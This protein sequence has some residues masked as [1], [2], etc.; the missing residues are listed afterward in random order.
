MKQKTKHYPSISVQTWH[1]GDL[2]R[3]EMFDGVFQ[4]DENKIGEFFVPATSLDYIKHVPPI[5]LHAR[6]KHSLNITFD[7]YSYCARVSKE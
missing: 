1:Q 7:H 2:V 3:V 5:I 6:A 4:K